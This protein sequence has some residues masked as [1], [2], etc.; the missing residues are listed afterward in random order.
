MHLAFMLQLWVL[1]AHSSIP[2][3]DIPFPL[4]PLL[5]AHLWQAQH[6]FLGLAI[7]IGL[8]AKANATAR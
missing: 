7:L 2:S 5:Q 3:Q 4:Y 8:R 6:V 1:V